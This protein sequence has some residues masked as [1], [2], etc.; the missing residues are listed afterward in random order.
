MCISPME[1]LSVARRQ[2]VNKI[3]DHPDKDPE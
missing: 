3:T 2:G 1:G